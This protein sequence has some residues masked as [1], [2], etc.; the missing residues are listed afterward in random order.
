LGIASSRGCKTIANPCVG[1]GDAIPGCGRNTAAV[2][3][4]CFVDK[5]CLCCVQVKKSILGRMPHT[6]YRLTSRGRKALK[7]YWAAMD[8]IRALGKGGSVDTA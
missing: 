8:E 3:G 2:L 4:I 1:K 6:Q 5:A 7:E